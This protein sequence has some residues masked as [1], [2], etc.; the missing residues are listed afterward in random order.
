M[1]ISWKKTRDFLKKIIRGFIYVIIHLEIGTN[2][3]E[4]KD[5]DNNINS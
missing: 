5:K 2:K 4:K 1:N 3:N